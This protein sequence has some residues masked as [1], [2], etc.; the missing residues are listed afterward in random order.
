MSMLTRWLQLSAGTSPKFV[1]TC[2]RPA[3]ACIGYVGLQQRTMV[4]FP[5]YRFPV[6]CGTL[7]ESSARSRALRC[8]QQ[9]AR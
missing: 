5:V 3:L 7:V 8:R 4:R 2:K 6:A 1:K 9:A